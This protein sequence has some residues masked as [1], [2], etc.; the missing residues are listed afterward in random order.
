M[1]SCHCSQCRRT[2]GHTGAYTSV[3]RSQLVISWDR[4]L[5]WY[6]SS[7]RARRGFCAAC[8]A[9]L[10]WD[11]VGG[12]EIAVSAGTLDPPTGLRTIRHVYVRD[13]GDYYMLEDGLEKYPGSMHGEPPAEPRERLDKG[14]ERAGL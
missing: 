12:D 2:H 11:P 5:Q 10:F 14:R 13:K 3:P 6:R 9:S 4:G 7:N 8:G 1:S